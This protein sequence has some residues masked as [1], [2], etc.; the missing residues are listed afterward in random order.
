MPFRRCERW[1]TSSLPFLKPHHTLGHPQQPHSLSLSLTQACACP[2]SLSSLSRKSSCS[3]SHSISLS[4]SL[5]HS[6]LRIKHQDLDQTVKIPPS[7]L[8]FFCW[9]IFWREFYREKIEWKSSDVIIV[10]R[11]MTSCGKRERSEDKKPKIFFGI[12][13]H[14]HRHKS[15]TTTTTTAMTTTTLPP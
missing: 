4:L 5:L 2:L 15:T 8:R 3:Y 10:S 12:L 13:H 6:S 7:H 9:K 1:V 14:R 11:L